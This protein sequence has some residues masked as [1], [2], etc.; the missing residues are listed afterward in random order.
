VIC[1]KCKK[2][3]GGWVC[4]YDPKPRET[5]PIPCQEDSMKQCPELT[6]KEVVDETI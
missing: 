4:L 6:K 5:A 2:R 1:A 3:R